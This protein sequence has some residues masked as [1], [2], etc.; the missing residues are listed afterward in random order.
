MARSYM[1]EILTSAVLPMLSCR[2]GAIHWQDNAQHHDSPMNIFKDLMY[3]LSLPDH[4]TARQWSPCGAF[5]ESNC[6]RP[7][8]R[9][10]KLPS[11]KD[12]GMIFLQLQLSAHDRR[13]VKQHESFWRRT[14]YFRTMRK[15]T[16]ELAPT[17][18]T[19]TQTPKAGLLVRTNLMCINSSIRQVFSNT[20]DTLAASM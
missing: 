9:L 16:P 4:Q 15:T 11:C 20:H 6:R 13:A 5:L 8:I 2:P 1:D 7:R 14:S 12:Y 3:F 17:L 18:Q 19:T 10:K